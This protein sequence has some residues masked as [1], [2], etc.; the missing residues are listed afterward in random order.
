MILRVVR[1][2]YPFL[3]AC[4]RRNIRIQAWHVVVGQLQNM[5]DR[6]G[7][8]FGSIIA[9]LEVGRASRIESQDSAAARFTDP[10]AAS[11]GDRWR[12]AGAVQLGGMRRYPNG[13]QKQYVRWGLGYLF[14][15]VFHS[16]FTRETCSEF[17]ST[18]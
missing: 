5:P 17:R 4:A 8:S 1:T 7:A 13:Q 9:R 12:L 14:P 6:N 11:Q 2:E 10:D 18:P 16:V 3:L 15:Q